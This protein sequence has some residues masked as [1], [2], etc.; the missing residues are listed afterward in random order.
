M[1]NTARVMSISWGSGL[2]GSGLA[3]SGLAGSGLAGSGLAGSGLAGKAH[4]VDP[5]VH[6]FGL[7]ASSRSH[8][9]FRVSCDG[10]EHKCMFVDQPQVINESLNTAAR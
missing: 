1:L 7:P 9:G 10:N 5:D 4:T 6:K 3:G 8:Q 2:A